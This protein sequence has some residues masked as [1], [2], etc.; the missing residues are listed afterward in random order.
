M[1]LTMTSKY[2][3]ATASEREAFAAARKP[4]QEVPKC[5]AFYSYEDACDLFRSHHC[6]P[7]EISL[8]L[9]AMMAGG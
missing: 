3:T 6:A 7:S 9:A 8:A 1:T 5:A 2:Q 4:G